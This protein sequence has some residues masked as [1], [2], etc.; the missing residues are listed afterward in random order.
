MLVNIGLLILYYVLKL[1]VSI[2]VCL[3]EW[4]IVSGVI[5][6]LVFVFLR[7]IWKIC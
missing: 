7:Y 1:I 4:I 2:R 5:V 3:L 6:Y